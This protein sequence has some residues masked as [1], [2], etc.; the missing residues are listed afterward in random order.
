M[1]L[2]SKEVTTSSDEVESSFHPRELLTSI[3][4]SFISAKEMEKTVALLQVIA[5]KIWLFTYTSVQS[6][7][8]D[9][10]RLKLWHLLVLQPVVHRTVLRINHIQW[11]VS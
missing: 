7:L 1:Q 9:S 6:E 8:N 4:L 3:L 5:N 2:S 10:L 11:R